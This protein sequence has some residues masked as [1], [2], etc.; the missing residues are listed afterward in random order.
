MPQSLTSVL[1][2]GSNQG[3]GFHLVQKLMNQANSLH[4][5][6]GARS[7]EKA[8][9]AVRV[10]RE[11]TTTTRDS[12]HLEPIVID[13]TIDST[14]EAAVEQMSSLDI[15]VNNAGAFSVYHPFG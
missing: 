12:V 14:I 7:M 15:L 1:V 9:E 11:T 2:T 4:I 6:V 8:A 10:L 5:Y 13:L 3:L